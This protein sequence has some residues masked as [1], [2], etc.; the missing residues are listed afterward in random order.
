MGVPE[1]I[2]SVYKRIAGTEQ[3]F[4]GEMH[5]KTYSPK[6]RRFVTASYLG[7]KTA[8]LERMKQDIPPV[9]DLDG[10]AKEHDISYY[11][12]GEMY[13]KGEIDK[14][15]FNNLIWQADDKFIP[16][17]KQSKDDPFTGMLASKA[18]KTKEY[19]EKEGIMPTATFS[20][21]GD[22]QHKR[23]K[24]IPEFVKVAIKQKK[25]CNSRTN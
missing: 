25:K 22:K 19:A 16:R 21:Y 15:T 9:N 13:R 4:P 18:M 1:N 12:T 20:G 2:Y 7:P 17:A 14:N 8:I 23:K 6:E 5:A 3:R 24:V 10:Y 11:K